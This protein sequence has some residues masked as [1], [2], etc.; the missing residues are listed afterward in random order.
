MLIC[1][2][3]ENI[4]EVRA[5]ERKRLFRQFIFLCKLCEKREFVDNLSPIHLEE[6][7]TRRHINSIRIMFSK[8]GGDFF[9]N[10]KVE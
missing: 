1:F 3:G 7:L 8:K 6:V 5:P 4:C 9:V 10:I 2:L